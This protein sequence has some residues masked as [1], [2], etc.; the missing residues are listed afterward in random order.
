M[1]ACAFALKDDDDK[2]RK[3]IA[4]FLTLLSICS[5]STPGCA[6]FH[7]TMSLHTIS[8][9]LIMKVSVLL[10]IIAS[11]STIQTPIPILFSY[12]DISIWLYRVIDDDVV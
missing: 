4:L 10:N 6:Y 9:L 1:L 7:T 3:E 5:L 8:C 11:M 12:D 2:R